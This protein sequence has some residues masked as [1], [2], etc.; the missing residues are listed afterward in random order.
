MAD[1]NSPVNPN[2]PGVGDTNSYAGAGAGG[3]QAQGDA[4]G[5]WVPVQTSTAA[6]TWGADTGGSRAR[7]PRGPGAS[8][9]SPGS[10]GT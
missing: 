7:R 9:A 5:D 10:T 1:A 8:D 3:P 2:G 6:A 4:P